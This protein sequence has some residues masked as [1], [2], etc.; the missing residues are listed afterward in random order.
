MVRR[1]QAKEEEMKE[2]QKGGR[3][4]KKLTHNDYQHH[5]CSFVSEGNSTFSNST[6]EGGEKKNEERGVTQSKK[7]LG[8]REI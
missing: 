2:E 6:I 4:V 8:G 1:L 7:Q 3:P 5:A